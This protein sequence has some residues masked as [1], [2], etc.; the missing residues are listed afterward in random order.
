MDCGICH[1]HSAQFHTFHLM[2]I[3]AHFC[4]RATCCGRSMDAEGEDGMSVGDACLAS[5]SF[6]STDVPGEGRL[7]QRYIGQCNIQTDIKEVTFLGDND[8]MVAAGGMHTP[9]CLQIF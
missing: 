9:T 5:A 8:E 3:S 1:S 2:M 7:V 4:T 6:S